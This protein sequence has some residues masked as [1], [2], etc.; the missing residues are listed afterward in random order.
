MTTND[1]ALPIGMRRNNPWNLKQFH[2]PW[3]GESASDAQLADGGELS[4]L[5]MDLGIRAGIRLCYTYQR[6]AWNEPAVFIPHFSPA[7]AGNPTAQYVLD[8]C[9]WTGY[10]KY[11]D[12]DFHDPD[13]MT[14]W[15]PA[16][17]RQEQGDAA[18]L[19]TVADILQAKAIADG[20]AAG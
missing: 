16:I 14:R 7:A 5:T 1:S 13:V 11:Q 12:L 19:I 18:S 20:L 15:A 10:E 9:K 3:L 4:F 17:W 6:R 2:I 8:V